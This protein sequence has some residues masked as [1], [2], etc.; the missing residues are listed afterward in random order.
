MPGG[1]LYVL[2]ATYSIP[3]NV[4]V[5]QIIG[6]MEG[7]IFGRDPEQDSTASTGCGASNPV[8]LPYYLAELVVVEV[9]KDTVW[10]L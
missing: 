10:D 2:E 1:S 5:A 4:I 6:F 7:S 3:R 9:G 8:T